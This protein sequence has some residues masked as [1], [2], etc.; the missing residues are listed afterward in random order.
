M[1][2]LAPGVACEIVPAACAPDTLQPYVGMRC[3]AIGPELVS[4]LLMALLS[5]AKVDHEYWM[6]ELEDGSGLT[7]C[8]Q[9]LRPID[10]PREDDATWKRVREIT[11]WA[12]TKEPA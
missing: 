10:P 12:P 4:S 11:G 5:G 3:T 9:C 2:D 8:R 7:L 6:V 1:P